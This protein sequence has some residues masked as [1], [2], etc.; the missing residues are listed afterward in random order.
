MKDGLYRVLNGD[1]CAA[2][3]VRKGE[4]TICAPVLRKRLDHWKEVAEFIP[5]DTSIPAPVPEPEI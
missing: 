3:V 2:F 1:I 5:T 4:V